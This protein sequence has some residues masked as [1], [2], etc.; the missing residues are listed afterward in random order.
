MFD[1][2]ELFIS[3]C[4]IMPGRWCALV[5]QG[6]ESSYLGSYTQ[7]GVAHGKLLL[8]KMQSPG[9]GPTQGLLIASCGNSGQ[10]SF[11]LWRLVCSAMAAGARGGSWARDQPPGPRVKAVPMPGKQV[12]PGLSPAE[13][14]LCQQG[15]HCWRAAGGSFHLHSQ[16]TEKTF[17]RIRAKFSS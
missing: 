12:S 7:G 3:S 17:I 13:G 9:L 15:P 5:Q 14:S 6:V 16:Q 11:R 4:L 2:C 1:R 10:P 8:S